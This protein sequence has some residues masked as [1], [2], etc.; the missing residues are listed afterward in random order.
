MKKR[1]RPFANLMTIKIQGSFRCAG[2]VHQRID[3]GRDI[4]D[5]FS[6]LHA[7]ID[8]LIKAAETGFY[9]PVYIPICIANAML[10]QEIV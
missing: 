7:A 8:L 5:N 10:K 6:F 3:F 2:F 1:I 4:T 9:Y